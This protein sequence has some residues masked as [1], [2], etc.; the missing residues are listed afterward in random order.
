MH[1]DG[2]PETRGMHARAAAPAADIGARG[3]AVHIAAA[4]LTPFN[5]GPDSSTA[6]RRRSSLQEQHVVMRMHARRSMHA[7]ASESTRQHQE[8]V[9]INCEA[10]VECHSSLW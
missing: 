7:H 6:G 1:H 10:A 5:T 2:A 4:V 9:D 8:T 3:L